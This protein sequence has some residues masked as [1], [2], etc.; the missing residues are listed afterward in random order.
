MMERNKIRERIRKENGSDKRMDKI[1]ELTD[2]IRE[3]IR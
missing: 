3:R 2:K 1:G